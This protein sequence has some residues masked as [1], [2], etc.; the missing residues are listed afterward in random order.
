MKDRSI[1]PVSDKKRCRGIKKT[2]IVEGMMKKRAFTLVEVLVV[3]AIL[4][5]LAAVGIPSFLNSQQSANNNMKEMN[6]STVNAAKEQWAIINNKS[7]GSSVTWENIEDYV[8][9]GIDE[10]CDLDVGDDSITI[11]NI[12][13]SA[14]Y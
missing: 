10:Q 2:R 3:V 1:C 13:T 12:G 14:S 5:L 7:P 6:I 11:N 9:G 4:G 8:G